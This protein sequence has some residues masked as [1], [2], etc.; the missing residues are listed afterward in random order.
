[1]PGGL[2]AGEHVEKLKIV[3]SYLIEKNR[4]IM[5]NKYNIR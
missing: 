2:V 1:M 5:L 3:L 4:C